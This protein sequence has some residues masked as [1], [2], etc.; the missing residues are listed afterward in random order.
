LLDST[1]S[2]IFPE[3]ITREIRT[4]TPNGGST[5]GTNIERS[6]E[7]NGSPINTNK[8]KENRN[9]VVQNHDTGRKIV[10]VVLYL[11]CIFKPQEVKNE[12]TNIHEILKCIIIN[13][14]GAFTSIAWF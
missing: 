7:K 2:K 12:T 6:L 11:L 10:A 14:M 5:G 4:K 8:Q 1:A 3:I 13:I 9:P